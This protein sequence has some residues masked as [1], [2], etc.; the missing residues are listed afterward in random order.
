MANTIGGV[1]LASIAEQTLDFLSTQFSPLRAFSRDFNDD[2]SGQG[3]SVTTRVATALTAQD[4]S[5]GYSATD[6]TSTAKTVTLSNLK[7]YSMA[8]TDMEVSKAGSPDFLA[9]I[10][11]APALE[12][13]CGAVMDSM[14]ALVTNA[15]FSSNEVITA[16]NFDSDECAD[17][18]ADLTV[19]KVPRTERSLLLPSTYMASV[20]KDAL[21]QDAS[22]YG[23]SDAIRDHGALRV[24][25]FDL[26]E[27]T[28]IPTNSENLAA[29]A[30]HPSAL[31]LAAR[32][33]AS[34][35]DPGVSVE[36]ITSPEGLPIQMRSWYDATAG[37]HY[38]SMAVL[39]GVAVGNAGA[40]KR[41]KSA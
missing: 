19:A 38:V 6:V 15:N 7:G 39:Y 2:I 10:F 22:A 29:I 21:I 23:N 13:T 24:H 18:S 11:L 31:L 30:L 9:S 12:V 35:D 3:E 20:Q 27:Y 16:A 37:K 26:Y 32:Q 36:N 1:N 40:L 17:L 34:P 5:T 41:V 25:G 28:G 33:P 4:L 8:F 14:L